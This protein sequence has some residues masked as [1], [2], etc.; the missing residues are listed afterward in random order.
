[1]A[2]GRNLQIKHC[3]MGE[4]QCGERRHTKCRLVRERSR[5]RSETVPAGLIS[6]DGVQMAERPGQ[7]E[8]AQKSSANLMETAR[9]AIRPCG[10]YQRPPA[11]L[12]ISSNVRDQ[13][14]AAPI[15][16]SAFEMA[17]TTSARAIQETFQ[18]TQCA[19][20]S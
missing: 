16:A 5:K 2:N 20:S 13:T 14:E 3:Y 19:G 12:E 8:K 15:G 7:T 10:R 11:W 4:Q 1:M 18:L 6:Q 9:N 17:K